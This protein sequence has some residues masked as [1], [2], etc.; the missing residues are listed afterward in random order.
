MQNL[1]NYDLKIIWLS[2]ENTNVR[3][4]SIALSEKRT[5]MLAVQ[6]SLAALEN[7]IQRERIIGR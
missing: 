7:A 5:A 4:L 6:D 3:S 2:R 1:A